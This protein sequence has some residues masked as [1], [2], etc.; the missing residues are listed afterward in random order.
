[1]IEEEL[2]AVF[3]AHEEQT[4]ELEPLRK[5]IDTETGR[6]RRRRTAVRT[7]LAGALAALVIAVP[8]TL[9]RG[10]DVLPGPVT[11]LTGFAEPSA[12]PVPS[13]ALNLLLLGLDQIGV[14]PDARADTVALLHLPADGHGAYLVALPRDLAVDIPGHGRH[15]LNAAYTYGGTELARR[16]VEQATGVR[17]DAVATVKLSSVRSIVDDLGGVPVCLPTSVKSRHTGHV[18]PAGCRDL[19]GGEAADLLRQRGNGVPDGAYGRDRNGQRVLLGLAQ[20]AAEL[21]L[22]LDAGKLRGLLGT[23]GVGLDTGGMSLLGLAM[24]LE[25]V[26]RTEIVGITQPG[27]RA[28][29]HGRELLD[30][31]VGPQLLAAL[32]QDGMAAFAAGH[33]DWLL[34]T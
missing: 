10:A 23:P 8:V 5:A 28:D 4:P 13:G 29:G 22:L 1:M 7:S 3:R 11:G 26:D 12:E 31:Q 15:R 18:Y 2:R 21:N 14:M 9:W 17:V 20:R 25:R 27:F 32:R 6:R 16:T 19:S 30:E 24:R 33:P 34:H